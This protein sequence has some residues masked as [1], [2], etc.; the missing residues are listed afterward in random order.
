[1]SL[2]SPLNI[3]NQ[4]KVSLFKMAPIIG[5]ALMIVESTNVS[6]LPSDNEQ[7]ITL[8][9]DHAEFDRKNG[10]TTYSGAVVMEQGSMKIHANKVVIY[11][12]TKSVSKIIAT[13]KPA[14]FQQ[15]PTQ[16]AKPVTAT[17]E[18]LEYNIDEKVLYLIKK[19][20]LQQDGSILSG[21]K[22][23]YDVKQSV[24]RAGEAE[25]DNSGR[26]RMVIP[27]SKQK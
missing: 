2:F 21:P 5:G 26:I 7:P 17:G 9:S 23:V 19:A 16:D 11:G 13:G 14:R 27:P 15:T 6:A 25:Q 4:L 12:K 8:Q 20:T 1:M 10:T 24:V 3:F 22:I 18:T